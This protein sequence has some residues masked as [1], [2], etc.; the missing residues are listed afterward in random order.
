DIPLKGMNPSGYRTPEIDNIRPAD[1][2]GIGGGTG[3]PEVPGP[4]QDPRQAA[5]A[6]LARRRASREGGQSAGVSTEM[7]PQEAARA[8]LMRRR[9]QK[10]AQSRALN[11]DP[12]NDWIAKMGGPEIPER[13]RPNPDAVDMSAPRTPTM[14]EIGIYNQADEKRPSREQ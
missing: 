5:A 3:G 12:D 11:V 9:E 14:E 10:A 1:G 13:M 7:S 2:R 4:E 6:E 8:E